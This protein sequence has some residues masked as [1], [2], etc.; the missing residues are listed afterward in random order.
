MK[1]G[2]I[3]IAILMTI[4][5]FTLVSATCDL[6]V[7]MINQDPYTAIPG[8][9]VKVVFQIDGVAEDE[10]K[11]VEFELLEEYPIE[12]DPETNPV[13]L[14]N[15]GFYAKDYGAFLIAPYK[16]RIDE[17]ALDGNNP[18]EIKVTYGEGISETVQFN[19]N[20]EDA[21]ADFEIH[22]KE[23]EAATNTITFEILN[24]ED[25]DVEALTVELPEQENIIVK[26]TNRNI[27]GD[28]DSNEYTTADFE[29]IPSEGK[30]ITR[31]I[32]T[33][34]TNKRRTIEKLVEFKPEYFEGRISDQKQSPVKTY[35][36]S[37]LVIVGIIY[38]FYRKNKKKKE[39]ERKRRY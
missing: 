13:V 32:Y 36:I 34:S 5:S 39:L 21:R 12:F 6:D 3:A 20:V 14:I 4:F 33:D 11:D 35:L 16:V 30:I 19:L 9:Y 10:C 31:L 15:S 29:A 28:L 17:D 8:D 1:K 18:I 27:V 2:V 26:N 22:I 37:I 7:T 23:Y 24:I 38:Y 25:S